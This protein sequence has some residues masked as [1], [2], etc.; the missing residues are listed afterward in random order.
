MRTDD[1]LLSGKKHKGYFLQCNGSVESQ[2]VFYVSEFNMFLLALRVGNLASIASPLI[3][4]ITFLFK[5]L[6]ELCLNYK[7][8]T[9]LMVVYSDGSGK[10][11]T[12]PPPKNTSAL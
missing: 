8:V 6:P 7:V 10:K 9:H 1:W 3:F 2:N 11:T 12:P 5:M 4:C